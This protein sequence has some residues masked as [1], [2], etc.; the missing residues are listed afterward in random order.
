LLRAEGGWNAPNG[1][2]LLVDLQINDQPIVRLPWIVSA[3]GKTATYRDDPVEF[4]R[5]IPEGARMKVAAAN[6]E[7]IRREAT[8]RLT[9][10]WAPGT[11]K[12]SDAI[13][14]YR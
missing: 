14:R 11:A 1:K 4:L 3:D 10:N 12:T 13:K 5:S 8:F 7:N 2:E 6:K 9:R